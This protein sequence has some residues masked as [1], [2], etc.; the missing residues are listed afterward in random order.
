MK[1]Y[2]YYAKKTMNF[3]FYNSIK[4]IYTEDA[5]SFVSLNIIFWAVINGILAGGYAKWEKQNVMILLST[6]ITTTTAVILWNWMIVFTKATIYLNVDH[7]IFR[8]SWADFLDGVSVFALV[9]FILGTFILRNEKA[10]IIAKIAIV[11]SLITIF[12][13]IFFF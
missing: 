3:L 10:I 6:F 12:T 2:I 9:S 8:I 7:P 1:V 4:S 5:M 11:S 13:D